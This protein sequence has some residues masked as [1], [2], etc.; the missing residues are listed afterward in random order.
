[1][2]S[3]RPVAILV[4]ALVG[5]VVGYLIWGRRETPPATEAQTAPA[6]P[7]RST[8]SF[9]TAESPARATR[10]VPPPSPARPTSQKQVVQSVRP[11]DG[12]PNVNVSAGSEAAPTS[13][14]PAEPAAWPLAVGASTIQGRV[15][16]IGAV[17]PPVRLHREADPYCARTEMFDPAV[18]VKNGRLANVWIHV[19]KGA[20]DAP[21]PSTAIAIDQKNCMYVPRVVAAVVGQRIV[22]KNGDP[23]LHNVHAFLGAST[24]FNKGMTNE[25]AAPLEQVARQ[26]GVV[27][28]KCDV[29]PWMRGYVGVSRNGLQAV[30][31]DAGAFR[32]ENVPPG[33][34]TIEA[35]HEKLGVKSLQLTVEP[36]RPAEAVFRYAGTE[37]NL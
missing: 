32:I 15:E 20:P 12:G 8:P 13:G 18:S 30:T 27:K 21:A 35:W 37:K 16:F 25:K 9:S 26:E 5:L 1:M 28:W 19:T 29:H 24:L 31:G 23:V 3:K 36:G 17:P 6:W 11:A 34:Y 2:R 14:A 10:P 7:D 33:D 22:A 4:A